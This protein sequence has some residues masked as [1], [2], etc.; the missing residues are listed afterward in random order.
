MPKIWLS[1][2]GGLTRF[3]RSTLGPERVRSWD[4]AVPEI[5]DVHQRDEAGACIFPVVGIECVCAEVD[6]GSAVE[7]EQPRFIQ[8]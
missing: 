2:S 7:T 6:R 4:G 1:W 5:L 3:S 8:S